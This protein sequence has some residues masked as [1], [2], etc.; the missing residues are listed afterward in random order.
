MDLR[1]TELIA[2]IITIVDTFVVQRFRWIDVFCSLISTFYFQRDR[3]NLTELGFFLT[4]SIVFV[5]LM[6]SYILLVF[7]LSYSLFFRNFEWCLLGV[8]AGFRK[9]ISRLS[10]LYRKVISIKLK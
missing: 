6:V 3:E 1:M 4:I 8:R 5:A 9:T 7:Q 2:L 10:V